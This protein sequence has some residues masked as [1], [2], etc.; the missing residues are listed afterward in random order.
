MSGEVRTGER[1]SQ[2][3]LTDHVYRVTRWVDLGDGKIRSLEKE[4]MDF[5][6]LGEDGTVLAWGATRHEVVGKAAILN[7]EGHNVRV[8][9]TEWLEPC[10]G[11]SE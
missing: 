2:S 9:P 3:P 5:A 8:Y 6:A 10:G 1:Y 11:D 7:R 4:R